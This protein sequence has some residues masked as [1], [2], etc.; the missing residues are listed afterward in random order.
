MSKHRLDPRRFTGDGEDDFD[1]DEAGFAPRKSVIHKHREEEPRRD[2]TN[3]HH[4]RRP[5]KHEFPE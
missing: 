3:K 4:E 5:R 2:K 1:D